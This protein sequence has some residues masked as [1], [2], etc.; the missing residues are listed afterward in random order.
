MRFSRAREA[1]LDETL[2]GRIVDTY[3]EEDLPPSWHV[4]PELADRVRAHPG[5]HPA[6]LG[7]RM[8][9]PFPA[10]QQTELALGRGLV[11]GFSKLLIALGLEPTEMATTVLPTPT[12]AEGATVVSPA[13]RSDPY[14]RLL[15]ACPDLADRW[16]SMHERLHSLDAVPPGA[17]E[18]GRRRMC[19]LL[20]V[21]ADAYQASGRTRQDGAGAAVD[22]GTMSPEAT[23][24][25]GATAE[26]FALDVRSI[27]ADLRR[28]LT[29]W[30]GPD[31]LVQLVMALAV[32][33]G[34]YR[35]AAWAAGSA[36][37]SE[38]R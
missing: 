37:A 4:A 12:P 36:A 38:E 7:A 35:V 18:V 10:E 23:N 2:A 11:H 17:L 26:A 32:Y 21:D 34:I 30:S 14:R 9:A 8:D 13:P 25:V 3:A 27:D 28:Q 16:C 19:L 29:E 5:P 31:G 33:D 20:G 6:G 15:M 22:D 1:G 24:L